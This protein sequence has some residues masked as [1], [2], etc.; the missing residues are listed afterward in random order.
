MNEFA[1]DQAPLGGWFSSLY[2]GL[3]TG[4]CGGLDLLIRPFLKPF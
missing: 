2:S 1:S 3:K 4:A